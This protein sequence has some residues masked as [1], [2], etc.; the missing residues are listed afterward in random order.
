MP[1]LFPWRSGKPAAL[2][3]ALVFVGALSMARADATA[4]S[5]PTA[6][7]AHAATASNESSGI[8]P[9]MPC[10][11]VSSQQQARLLGGL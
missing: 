1:A 4:G 11:D 3:T 8:L 9:A 5:A 2:L 10:T 6:A 7:T